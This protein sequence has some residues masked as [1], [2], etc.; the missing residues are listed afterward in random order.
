MRLITAA[1]VVATAVAADVALAAALLLLP[2][3]G[4]ASPPPFRLPASV[5]DLGLLAVVRAGVTIALALAGGPR[6]AARAAR[7]AS[8]AALA[9]KLLAVALAAPCSEFRVRQLCQCI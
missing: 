4:V 2:W 6:K 5:V 8:F 9:L 7:W 3:R 1:L